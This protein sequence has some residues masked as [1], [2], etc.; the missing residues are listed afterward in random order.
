MLDEEDESSYMI[1]GSLN[2]TGNEKQMYPRCF[3]LL[4]ELQ[5]GNRLQEL[6]I[7]DRGRGFYDE[8]VVLDNGKELIKDELPLSGISSDNGDDMIELLP[9]GCELPTCSD[10]P[11]QTMERSTSPLHQDR[12]NEEQLNDSEEL[13]ELSAGQ[14]RTRRKPYSSED[15][16]AEALSEMSVRGLNLFRYAASQE[17]GQFQCTE[18]LK[19]GEY[20]TFKN[21][22][23]VQRHAFLYHEGTKRK[24]FPCPL[25]NKA[26]SRPDKMKN[27]QR[28]AHGIPATNCN[29]QTIPHQQP[30]QSL[31]QLRAG[32][33]LLRQDY[34]S[35]QQTATE[36]A[37]QLRRLQQE[38]DVLRI[39]SVVS[40][41]GLHQLHQQQDLQ[42]QYMQHAAH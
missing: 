31:E 33:S 24:V 5:K 30:Q 34:R 26:F 35:E 27:H 18:C 37:M 3:A 10:L 23:S 20:K 11:Y 2:T 1:G 8:R 22:Y 25:C 16:P 32:Q 36:N 28:T 17:N 39:R 42:Q 29:V 9:L 7:I 4:K 38:Q 6:T 13:E 19:K 41:I 15:D 21:K 12:G 14:R 40:N